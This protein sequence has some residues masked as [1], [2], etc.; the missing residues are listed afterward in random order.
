MLSPGPGGDTDVEMGGA[1]AVAGPDSSA[2]GGGR[3][4]MSPVTSP[5]TDTEHDGIVLTTRITPLL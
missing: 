4:G 5:T 3:T 1:G 2:S